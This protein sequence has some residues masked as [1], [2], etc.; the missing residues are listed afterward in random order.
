M[1]TMM[2]DI[3]CFLLLKCQESQLVFVIHEFWGFGLSVP[4]KKAI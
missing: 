2:S 3:C 4:G 1:L